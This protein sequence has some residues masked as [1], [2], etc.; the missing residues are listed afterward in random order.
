MAAK[1]VGGLYLLTMA[2]G[3]FGEIY[4]RGQLVVR[5]DAMQT[6]TNIVANE[7]LF[8]LGIVS[9]L[10]TLVG[11]AILV[12]ALYVVLRPIQRNLA[13]LAAFLRLIALAIGAAGVANAFIALR[14]LGGATY[15]QSFDAPQLQALSR[16]FISAQ[17]FGTQIDYVFFGLGSTVFGYLWLKSRYIPRVLAAVGLF[18]SLLLAIGGLLIMVFSSLADA[19][20]LT[21]MMP[22]GIFE[23]TL[24]LW[25][26]VKGL[27]SPGAGSPG[28]S[29]A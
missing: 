7:R 13:S 2:T 15:L 5:N 20:S 4:V 1:V 8:R 25:L 29:D 18:G 6:A 3:V 10:L 9:D 21:Y 27:Q 16:V 23:I 19:L 28:S 17:G 24:G 26:L 22:L 12:W 14:L 11:V